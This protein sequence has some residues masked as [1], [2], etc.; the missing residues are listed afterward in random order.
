LEALTGCKTPS[1]SK[2]IVFK[3]FIR[4]ITKKIVVAFMNDNFQT[5]R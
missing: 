5:K 4:T 3:V 1:K 2:K